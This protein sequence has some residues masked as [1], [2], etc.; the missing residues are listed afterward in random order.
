MIKVEKKYYSVIENGPY[1][2]TP[3]VIIL[4]D[5]IGK[6]CKYKFSN[7]VEATKFAD[8]VGTAPEDEYPTPDVYIK[9]NTS[10]IDNF[11]KEPLKYFIIRLIEDNSIRVIIDYPG[12]FIPI[13][14]EN[15]GKRASDTNLV[16]SIIQMFDNLR[17]ESKINNHLKNIKFVITPY[18]DEVNHP[19]YIPSYKNYESVDLL[20]NF[21]SDKVVFNF[22]YSSEDEMTILHF[23]NTWLS[24]GVDLRRKNM[25]CVT[26]NKDQEQQNAIQ[27]C[28]FNAI[29]FQPYVI[30]KEYN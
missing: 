3:A 1:A 27:F 29:K 22:H 2:G 9:W 24:Y 26:V 17:I 6:E 11:N 15:S 4:L 12:F 28:K 20:N 7:I 5:S 10:A 21:L 13:N 16:P 8:L 14:F 30:D 25:V 19:F 18:I 23:V